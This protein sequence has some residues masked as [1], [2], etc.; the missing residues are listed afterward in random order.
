MATGRLLVDSVDLWDTYRATLLDGGLNDLLSWPAAKE[1]DVEAW[2]ER[3]F[4]SAD[5][6]DI[7]LAAKDMTLKFGINGHP[8]DVRGI[9]DWLASSIYRTWDIASAERTVSLRYRG[10]SSVTVW[11]TLQLIG[12]DLS[13]DNPLGSYEYAAPVSHIEEAYDYSLDGNPLTDYGVRVLFGTLDSTASAGAV[14]E[15]LRRD[16]STIDGVIY[17]GSGTNRRAEQEITLSCALIDTSLSNAWRNYDALLYDLIRKNNLAAHDTD[18][19]KRT[20]HSYRLN[21]DFECYYKSQ[22]VTDFMPYGGKIWLLFTVT[23]GVVGEAYA[24]ALLAAETG[25]LVDTES[26]LKI[27]I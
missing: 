21:Y 3:D 8:T 6:S 20:L 19:C 11:P 4:V 2:A 18:K 25:N 5:L 14:K 13:Q 15:L 9:A 10:T 26:G 12:I 1:V 23:L 22:A 24:P 7:K 16:I 27:R 17:D